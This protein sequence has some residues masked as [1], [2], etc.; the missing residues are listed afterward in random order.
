MSKYQLSVK[1]LGKY[2]LSV[3]PIQTLLHAFFVSYI[4]GVNILI[5]SSQN[6]LWDEKKIKRILFQ[7]CK[8]YLQYR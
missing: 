3:N 8:Q 1:T 2:Q 7:F 6:E 4:A 5:I